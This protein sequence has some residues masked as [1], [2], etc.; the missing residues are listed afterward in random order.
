MLLKAECH[1]VLLLSNLVKINRFSK[2]IEFSFKQFMPNRALPE[3]PA[4]LRN[5]RVGNPKI[6]K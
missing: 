3:K 2:K 6:A 1:I 5:A 4:N